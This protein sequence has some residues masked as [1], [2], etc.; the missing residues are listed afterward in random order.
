M[1]K[2]GIVTH[3]YDKIGVAIITLDGLLAVR[4][5]VRFTKNGEYLFE[6]EITEIQV[7]HEKL[8]SANKGT[9]IGVKTLQVVPE[10]TEVF[11]L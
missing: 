7:G 2:V 6:Q 9:L 11:K 5:K 4:D 10:G 1:F 8:E 3:Y